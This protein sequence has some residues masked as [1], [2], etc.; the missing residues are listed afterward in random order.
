MTLLRLALRRDRA[1]LPAWGYLLLAVMLGTAFS[2]RSLYPTQL[3]RDQFAAALAG[4]RAITAIYGP[5]PLPASLG[6]LVSWRSL[7]LGAVLLA[8]LAILL[9]VRHTRADEQSGALE[10]L[11]ATAVGRAAPLAAALWTVALAVAALDVAV[12]LGGLAAGLPAAGCLTYAGAWAGVGLCF[13][14]VA[15]VAAQLVESARTA[16]ALSLLVLGCCYVLRLLGDTEVGWLGWLTPL[17]WAERMRPFH[18]DRWWPLVLP[19]LAGG[20]LIRLAFV[21][22]QRR[23]LFSGM[24]AARAGR[25]TAAP[26]LRS[27]VALTVRL[28][29]T[30]WLSWLAG[31][32]V[33]GALFGG[34][35]SSVTALG[36]SAATRR[37]LTELGGSSD[38]ADGFLGS[39]LNA[40]ALILTGYGL[41]ALVAAQAEEAS[42]RLELL[43]SG[44]VGR[45]RWFATQLVAALLGTAGLLAAVGLAAGVARGEALRLLG[46]SLVLIPAAW[47]VIA[48]CALLYSVRRTAATA[49]W[50]LLGGCAVLGLLGPVLRLPRWLLDLSPFTHVPTA[51]GEPVP[52]AAVS[53]LLV[54]SALA[55]AGAV[56]QLGRRDLG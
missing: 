46:T 29:R 39:S 20:A 19:L 34:L 50:A 22:Q 49:G 37:L 52:A 4:S 16:R 27:P 33:F 32:L 6:D 8:C 15:A 42:G 11:A 30:G 28:S 56:W 54:V 10:L 31:V 25:A 53:T 55:A 45:R 1:M 40:G 48:A 12:V 3:D 17:G 21:L 41:A 36:D 23:D 18:G 26:W 24:L 35:A 44:S 7:V 38:L 43:L 13:A 51:P 2:F 14:G 5:L 47:T 9:V